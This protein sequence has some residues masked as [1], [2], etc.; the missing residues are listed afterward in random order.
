MIA[1]FALLLAAANPTA[2]PS[3]TPTPQAMR[4][5]PGDYRW[6]PFTVKQ[7]PTEAD[8]RFEVLQGGP[9][10]HLELLPMGEFRAFSRNKEHETLAVSPDSM[11]GAFRRMIDRPGQYAVVLKNSSKSEPVVVSLEFSTNLNPNA[12]VVAQELPPHKRLMVILIS[13]GVF[14]AMVSWS[15]VQLIRGL[16]SGR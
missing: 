12:N 15:G 11:K 5:E 9:S 13:F 8:C 7:I 16:K 10:V 2:I 4:L 3:A 1:L 6:V 14:F